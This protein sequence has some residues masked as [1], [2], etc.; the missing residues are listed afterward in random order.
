MV[1][2]GVL[3]LRH[4]VLS[5][6][7]VEVQVGHGINRNLQLHSTESEFARKV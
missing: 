1:G 4:D 2:K 3:R 7:R 5:G 6:L